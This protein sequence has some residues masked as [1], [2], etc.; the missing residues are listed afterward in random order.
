MVESEAAAKPSEPESEKPNAVE[1]EK[2]QQ[3][4]VSSI[5]D[6]VLDEA[7]IAETEAQTGKH[8]NKHPLLIDLVLGLGLL[9]AMAGFTSGLMRMYV[10]HSAENCI[11]E[12]NYKAAIAL[13]EGS[14]LP[15]FF[16]A[17][18]SEPKELLNRAYYL[19]AVRRLNDYDADPVALKELEK[20]MPDSEFFELSQQ[21]LTDH[22]TP[23]AVTLSGGASQEV[24]V[25]EKDLNKPPPPPP[26]ENEQ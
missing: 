5:L 13:L 14:K 23:S 22:F 17:P 19:D 12:G 3:H 8:G 20:I 26:V 21:I 2:L 4:H 18:S 10:A 16:A 6:N 7:Q 25:S 11:T 15:D 1:N 9:F 24:Q